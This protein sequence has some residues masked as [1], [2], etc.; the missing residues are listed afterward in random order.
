MS[1]SET[2]PPSQPPSWGAPAPPPPAG[3]GDN[4]VAGNELSGWA[5]AVGPL[6]GLA[7][8]AL[9]AA[10]SGVGAAVTAG[11]L[12][13]LAVNALLVWWDATVLHRRGVKDI[14]WLSALILM[15][16]YLYS[17]QKRLGRSQSLMGVWIVAFVLS[18]ALQSS[19]IN[20][21]AAHR[22]VQLDTAALEQQIESGTASRIP[23]GDT[24]SCPSET[25]HQGMTFQCVLTATSDGSTAFVN[26]TVENNNGDVIWRVVP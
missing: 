16:A 26:V 2:P 14:P 7:V 18:V 3:L 10:N 13:Y 25:L 20:T 19:V 21:A 6:L 24:V 11:W 17:R 4:L 23:G 1:Y 8:S 9:I 15:P 22:L 12:V 5:V